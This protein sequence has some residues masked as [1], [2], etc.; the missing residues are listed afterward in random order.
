M[1]HHLL[2][3]G[4]G[5]EKHL[6]HEYL[7]QFWGTDMPNGKYSQL[8]LPTGKFKVVR[9]DDVL[10]NFICKKPLLASSFE[11]MFALEMT[12]MISSTVNTG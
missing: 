4:F 1:G 6:V 5:C 12:A 7:K 11:N 9:N 3:C 2:F 8:Y 10:S